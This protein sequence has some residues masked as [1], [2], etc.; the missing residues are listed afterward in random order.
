MISYLPKRNTNEDNSEEN[1]PIDPIA[2]N[3]GSVCVCVAYMRIMCLC[4]F[5]YV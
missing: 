3:A 2:S 1:Y 5:V 4:V